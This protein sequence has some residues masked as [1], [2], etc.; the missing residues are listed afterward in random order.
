MHVGS[1]NDIWKEIKAYNPTDA[2]HRG[3]VLDAPK[4][5]G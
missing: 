5:T 1:D 4:E 2:D 3:N